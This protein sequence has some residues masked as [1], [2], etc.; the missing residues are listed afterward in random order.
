M[1]ER[2]DD[3][4]RLG[5]DLLDEGANEGQSGATRALIEMLTEPDDI[6]RCG[7]LLGP[8]VQEDRL[9]RLK[10]VSLLEDAGGQEGPPVWRQR[11]IAEIRYAPIANDP[12]TLMASVPIGM[13]P[14]S[15][16]AATLISWRSTPP[17]PAP[18]NTMR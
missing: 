3:A 11:W 10:V 15:S 6:A 5:A 4:R 1:G 9:E 14:P 2:A 17:M 18:R 8:L 7:S 12:A 16:A 13:A